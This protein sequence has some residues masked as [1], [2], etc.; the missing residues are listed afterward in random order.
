M[1]HRDGR[2]DDRVSAE[3]LDLE[4]QLRECVTVGLERVCFGWTKVKRAECW[5]IN[6][7]PSPR[8]NIR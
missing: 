1:R 2:N 3:R 8:S 5:S 6:T 7:T 4:A